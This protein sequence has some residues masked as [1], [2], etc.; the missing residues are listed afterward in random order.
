MRYIALARSRCM[1]TRSTEKELIEVSTAWLLCAMM[2][3]N[4]SELRSCTVA[5]VCGS[6]NQNSPVRAA[7]STTCSRFIL[8]SASPRRC[9]FSRP[10]STASCRHQLVANLRSPSCS[11]PL[12]P[13][14]RRHS[15]AQQPALPCVSSSWPTKEGHRKAHASAVPCSRHHTFNSKAGSH[16]K[17]Q[18]KVLPDINGPGARI[19]ASF[20]ITVRTRCG[21]YPAMLPRW[22]PKGIENMARK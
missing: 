9:L 6:W 4:S 12:P 16:C 8:V 3:K 18:T 1:M 11:P 7:L 2:T 13:A 15:D 10:S 17:E 20:R 14:S 22:R 21:M 19:A 5:S